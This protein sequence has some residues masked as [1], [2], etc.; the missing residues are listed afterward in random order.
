MKNILIMLA[1][2]GLA[3]TTA[4]AQS[5]VTI[6]TRQIN[7]IKV[8]NDY[9]YAESTSS[10]W[11]TAY[12]NAKALLEVNVEE[13]AK[14]T[15]VDDAQGCIV[16]AQNSI[17]KIQSRRGNLYRAFLYVR[18]ADIQTFSTPKEVIVAVVPRGE[19]PAEISVTTTTEKPEEIIIEPSYKTTE[20]ENEFLMV[21]HFDDV[22]LFIKSYNLTK[23]Q[24]GKFS[25]MP[26]LKAN[27]LFVYNR[28]GQIVAHLL[29]RNAEYI[30]VLTGKIDSIDNYK[31]CG[32]IWF[33]QKQ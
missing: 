29:Y 27:Y 6:A 5:D 1:M 28:A 24:Y 2:F 20:F 30:N 3:I 11:E 21:N 23:G 17:F 15:N 19:A 33:L 26:V 4:V 22:E 7:S 32:A 31:G 16:K 9:I 13:W 14:E 18:K 10:D 8:D 25:T 12:D